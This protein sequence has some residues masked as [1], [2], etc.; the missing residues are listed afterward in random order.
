VLVFYYGERRGLNAPLDLPYAQRACLSC[1]ED[2]EDRTW[3]DLLT[4]DVNRRLLRDVEYPFLGVK[5]YYLSFHCRGLA[6]KRARG[7]G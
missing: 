7:K 6:G 5:Y 1:I 4:Q 3:E 2:S